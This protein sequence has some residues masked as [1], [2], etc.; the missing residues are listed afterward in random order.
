MKQRS[1][2]ARLLSF[3][4]VLSVMLGMF[5]L[6]ATPASAAVQTDIPQNM[7]DNSALRSLEYLGYNLD[8]QKADGT[9]YVLWGNDSIKYMPSPY[10][11]YPTDTGIGINGDNLQ[12]VGK[13]NYGGGYKYTS[14]TGYAP[15]VEGFQKE[16]LVCAGYIAYYVFGY[17]PHIEGVNISRFEDNYKNIYDYNVQSVVYWYKTLE[18]ASNAN[19]TDY[20]KVQKLYGAPFDDLD[21]APTEAQMTTFRPG[22]IILTGGIWEEG[23]PKAGEKRYSHAAIYAGYYNGRHWMIEASDACPTGPHIYPFDHFM[24]PT[25]WKSTSHVVGV[26][27][28]NFVPKEIYQ[29]GSIQVY[30]TDPNGKALAGAQFLV[31]NTETGDYYTLGPTD[32]NGYAKTQDMLPFGTYTVKET[33]FPT[34]YKAGDITEWTVIINE[35]MPQTITINAINKP[36]YGKLNIVKQTNTGKNLSGWQIGVYTDEACTKPLAGSPYT[37]GADG[38]VLIS[39]L[40]P[41]TYYAKEVGIND[42]YWVCDSSV[43]KVTV[44]ADK[45]SSVT[46]SNTHY[47]KLRIKKNAVN[48]S[49]EGWSFQIYN[50]SNQLVETIKTGTDGYAYSAKLAPGTYKVVEVKDRSETYWTYDANIEKSVTVTAGAQADVEYTNTQYGKLRIKK[51]AVNGSAEGWSFQIYNAS[52]QLVET[53]KTGKDGYAYS[54]KLTPGTYKVVE[55]KDRSETYWTYDAN[56]EKS[57]TVTAGAQTDLQYTNTQYGKLRVR[58]TAVNGSAEGWS[59]Q[60][61][62]SSNQLVTTLKT[63]ASGQAYSGKL[64]PGQYRIVE[65]Q[66]RDGIYWTYD[67]QIEKNVTVLAGGQAVITYTNTQYGR[68]T[69]KKTTNTGNHLDGWTFRVTDATGNHVGDYTTDSSGSV[70]T[71]KLVPGRYHVQELSTSDPYWVCDLTTHTLDVTAGS[72]VT[73]TWKNTEHGKAT[74]RKTTNTGE[75]LSGWIISI[76]TDSACT[77]ELTTVTTGEGGTASVYLEPGTYYAKETGDTQNRFGNEYWQVDTSVQKFT[78][79]H[80]A[81]TAVTFSNTHYGKLKVQKTMATD[82][83]LSGWKFRVTD[84]AGTEISGSPFVSAADGTILTGNLLPGKYTVEELI[85]D[86]SLYYCKSDNPQTITVAQGQTATVSFTNALRPGKISIQKVNEDGASLAGAK[87]LLQWSEDGKTWNNVAYSAKADVVKG[88]C[89]NKTLVDGTLVTGEDGLLTWENLYPGIQYRITELEA[90][91]GYTLL[92]DIAW[93]GTLNADDLTVSLR[94]VNTHTLVLPETGSNTLA[95]MPLW[96]LLCTAV[97]MGAVFYLRRKEV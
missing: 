7:W 79:T 4:M 31:T 93:E 43:K 2:P 22:D 91:E 41:G 20:S 77:K 65:V 16:G 78:V 15:W 52:N 64:A 14:K 57:V 45:T 32:A 17:L 38:T 82:G 30:K 19:N 8:Q 18:L 87:F 97:C 67:A 48:G 26:Y 55:V 33:V 90:P 1:I 73:S 53:I 9:L 27:R 44:E 10:P 25:Q 95:L 13:G 74:F 61:Y 29:E 89:S 24:D 21:A 28:L 39:N 76:Y 68:M 83:P 36:N 40:E 23:T 58:K 12:W 62:N 80:H 59:F 51:N 92:T 88:G 6:F 35:T 46:F 5:P 60:V 54:G 72:T 47:G 70:T 49:A 86:G 34:G 75:N 84:A 42:P 3:L 56:I 37:T 96:L 11:F 66:D 50:A 63:D 85:P 69:F 71:G 81:E 94:V